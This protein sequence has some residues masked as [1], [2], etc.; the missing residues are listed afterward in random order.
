MDAGSTSAAARCPTNSTVTPRDRLIREGFAV[1]VNAMDHGF[2]KLSVHDPSNNEATLVDIGFD[3]AGSPATT[4]SI[5][6]VRAL[7]DL[8]GDKLLALFGRAAPRD[9]VDVDALR[10][11]FACRELKSFVP[12][13]IAGST[14]RCCVRRSGARWSAALDP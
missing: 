12:P 8:A 7:D 10:A 13:S 3:P 4:M 11:R 9:F 2:A 1:E 6:A 14:C 5:G